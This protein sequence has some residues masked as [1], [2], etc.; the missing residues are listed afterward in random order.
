MWRVSA[1]RSENGIISD[2]CG[3]DG[4]LFYYGVRLI[5][6]Q[7]FIMFSQLLLGAKDQPSEPF[8]CRIF[9]ICDCFADP[10]SR[11][12]LIKIR[13]ISVFSVLFH[14]SARTHKIKIRRPLLLTL[15]HLLVE[16]ESIK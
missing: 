9:A 16:A 4:L 2:E 14:D 7:L 10:S 1:Q 15:H 3:P 8:S 12:N 5:G 13:L 6:T 11:L